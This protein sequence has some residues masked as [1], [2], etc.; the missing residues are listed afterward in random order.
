MTTKNVYRRNLKD[1]RYKYGESAVDYFKLHPQCEVC[2]ER[3]L[4]LLCIHH[5]EGKE[6]GEFK[7]LFHNFHMI[8]HNPYVADETYESYMER[9]E[10]LMKE[11]QEKDQVILS[12]M[13]E[14]IPIR[15]IITK[16]HT[17]LPRIRRIASENG[18]VVYH[19]KGYEKSQ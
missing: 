4:V 15:N 14:Q 8:E 2:G 18:F 6:I 11:K 13:N 10:V 7:T 5:P 17:S 3:R 19:R 1:I 16:A 12:M 9:Q